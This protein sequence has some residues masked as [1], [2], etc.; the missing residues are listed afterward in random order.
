M[1]GMLRVFT[2][3]CYTL[4]DPGATCSFVTPYVADRFE[5]LPECLLEPFS[6]STPTSEPI[7]A[8]RVYRDCVVSIYH[9]DTLADLIE[10]EMVDFYVI[11][12]MDWLH[13]CYASVDCRTRTVKF[14][15]P[16]EPVIEWKGDAMV[17]KGR[18]IFYLKARK[19]ISKGCIYHLV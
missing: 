6:I 15:F 19:L 8:E 4:L 9:R 18:F 17:S 1:T 16:N 14:Q 2:L 13:A 12:G 3:D 7:R 11:L 10:L 5:I